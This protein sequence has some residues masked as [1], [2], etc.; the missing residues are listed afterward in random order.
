MAWP[1]WEAWKSGAHSAHANASTQP[2]VAAQTSP[3]SPARQ[4]KPHLS[5]WREPRHAAGAL[6]LAVRCRHS[7]LAEA[8]ATAAAR[9]A[10]RAGAIAASLAR[11]AA[12]RGAITAGRLR[13]W[14]T[15]AAAITAGS[16]ASRGAVPGAGG[17]LLLGG[18]LAG[19]R[20]GVARTNMVVESLLGAGSSILWHPLLAVNA[21]CP[22]AQHP[23]GDYVLPRDEPQ[24]GALTC[25]PPYPEP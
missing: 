2:A 25:A 6:L 3:S 24:Q 18:S 4:P 17:G 16:G 1:G 10:R 7:R 14:P 11:A 21:T 5:S 13:R 22:P 9:R 8:A 19:G 12:G 15:G 20:G 23:H